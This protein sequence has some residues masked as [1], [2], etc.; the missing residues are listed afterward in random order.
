M[1]KFKQIEFNS[2]KQA[3]RDNQCLSTIYYG[4]FKRHNIQCQRIKGHDGSHWHSPH[5]W[6]TGDIDEITK[7]AEAGH[8][9][10]GG[11]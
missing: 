10:A 6:V 5:E 3:M 9:Q 11:S 8:L 7:A 1:F 2:E 4:F